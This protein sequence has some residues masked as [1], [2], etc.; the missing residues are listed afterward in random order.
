M[1]RTDRER[2]EA[3]ALAVVDKCEYAVLAMASPEGEPLCLP[4]TIV[5]S[6]DAIYFHSAMEGEKVAWLRRNPRVCMSCVGDTE[7][8]PQDF[9]TAYE[10]AVVK[11]TAEEVTE[12]GEKIEALR[13]LCQRHAASAMD[14]FDSAIA[15]SLH[16]TG[17][18]KITIREI[19]GKAKVKKA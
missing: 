15:R 2:D 12:E 11:G 8:L 5:R 1:R 4:V 17:I 14:K 19:T 10:S 13:L 6:G 18:W 16:R 7:I 3:F 9:T